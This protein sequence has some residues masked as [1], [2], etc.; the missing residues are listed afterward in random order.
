MS[1][2]KKQFP[3]RVFWALTRYHSRIGTIP[4]LASMAIQMGAREI[5]FVGMDGYVPQKLSDKYKNT[6]FE[7]EKRANGYLEHN[8]GKEEQILELYREQYLTFWDYILHDIGKGVKFK[9]LGEGHPCNL[10]DIVLKEKIGNN[11]SE[12]L[13]SN[14]Q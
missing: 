10:S 5:H 1:F 3:N 4:R 2:L 14:R 8:A 12:Y 11:Y 13:M 9:N 7:S 6:C